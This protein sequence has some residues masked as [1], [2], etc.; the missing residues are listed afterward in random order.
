MFGPWVRPLTYLATL[1]NSI[2]S[3]LS[4]IGLSLKIDLLANWSDKTHNQNTR[5]AFIHDM[6]ACL[7]CSC[8]Y[9]DWDQSFQFYYSISTVPWQLPN[10]LT[11]QTCGFSVISDIDY[12]RLT[13]ERT[14]YC[15]SIAGQAFIHFHSVLPNK[16]WPNISAARAS[17]DIGSPLVV[18]Q[19]RI[20]PL[21]RHNWSQ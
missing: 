4:S 16:A 21:N 19:I 14:P 20:I 12:C 3:I 2:A 18:S 5:T 6:H 17:S 15:K 11:M 10:T 1:R 7:S 8:I 9:S 13:S